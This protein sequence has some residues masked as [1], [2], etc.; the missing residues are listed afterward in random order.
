MDVFGG[1][2]SKKNGVNFAQIEQYLRIDVFIF[3][4]IA[5]KL[6]WELVVLHDEELN[7]FL[8]L[9]V[10]LLELFGHSAFT[11]PI[12]N[13]PDLGKFLTTEFDEF[14][15]LFVGGMDAGATVGNVD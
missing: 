4:L 2:L 12:I 9:T 15:W 6:T 8:P 11:D 10:L 1:L 14:L 13:S 7:F 5:L 3:A